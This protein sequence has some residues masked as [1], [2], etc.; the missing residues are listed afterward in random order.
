MAFGNVM[1]MADEQSMRWVWGGNY[2]VRKVDPGG[3]M[4]DRVCLGELKAPKVHRTWRLAPRIIRGPIRKVGNGVH[5]L[6]PRLS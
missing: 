4:R 6:V 5:D 2:G 3:L 1:I